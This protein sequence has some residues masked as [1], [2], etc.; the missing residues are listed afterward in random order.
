MNNKLLS[1]LVAIVMITSVCVIPVSSDDGYAAEGDP[2]LKDGDAYG[3]YLDLNDNTINKLFSDLTESEMNSADV[4]SFIAALTQTLDKNKELL[5]N[6][7]ID[8]GIPAYTAVDYDIDMELG[9]GIKQVSSDA[10]GYTYRISVAADGDVMVSNTVTEE[11]AEGQNVDLTSTI[12]AETSIGLELIVVTDMNNDITSVSGRIALYVDYEA[13]EEV[14]TEVDPF[15]EEEKST[16]GKYTLLALIN[17]PVINEVTYTDITL[18]Q[19]GIELLRSNMRTSDPLSTSSIERAELEEIITIFNDN[20]EKGKI[21]FA[22]ILGIID[23]FKGDGSDLKKSASVIAGM[24]SDIAIYDKSIENLDSLPEFLF[25]DSGLKLSSSEE[26][27]LANATTGAINSVI[28]E[29]EDMEFDVIFRPADGDP[30]TPIK[31]KW[32]Q[33]VEKSSEVLA[34]ENADDGKKFVGWYVDMDGVLI[35][36]NIS[37][38]YGDMELVPVFS[39][40]YSGNLDALSI[41]NGASYWFDATTE[42]VFNTSGFAGK[43]NASV[44]ISVPNATGPVKSIV[45]TISSV[46]DDP[47]EPSKKEVNIKFTSEMKD[48]AIQINFEHSGALPSG[49]SV[50]VDVSDKFKCISTYAVV[51]VANC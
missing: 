35:P 40:I 22:G 12:D 42:D 9:F 11:I 6:F 24:I 29:F 45:W 51:H 20:T 41:E 16:S 48:D 49:T 18:Y 1:A 2:V 3:V 38:V 39:T 34:L 25:G 7:G 21:T 8:I 37:K 31:V 44:N 27:K 10:S 19:S 23:E 32:G 17:A 14:V 47:E 30:L 15:E 46:L 43:T 28:D 26:N 13:T 36:A 33:P 5:S 50:T 4:K